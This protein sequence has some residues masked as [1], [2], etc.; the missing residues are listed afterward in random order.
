MQTEHLPRW[1]QPQRSSSPINVD[2][3]N[4][5]LEKFHNEN[6]RDLSQEQ[7][8]LNLST[9]Q[10]QHPSIQ[11]NHYT[12]I[13]ELRNTLDFQPAQFFRNSTGGFITD[14][15]GGRK[16]NSSGLNVTFLVVSVSNL[17]KSCL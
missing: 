13:D 17:W 5:M 9:P 15:N 16:E 2:S 4:N 1:Y 6:I 14:G 11:E 8:E 12:V 10:H 7:H 3:R